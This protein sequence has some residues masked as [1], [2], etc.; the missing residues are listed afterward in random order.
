LNA[1]KISI[2]I[3]VYNEI[4][5]LEK[6]LDKVENT[7]FCSL[8]KEIILV[9][10]KSSDGTGD[11]LRDL[12][13]KYAETEEN[14]PALQHKVYFHSENMGKGGAI[15]TALGYA[16]GDI[17][18]I[19]DADLE[20]DPEDYN[21]LIPF[22]LEDKADVVYGSRL[23]GEKTSETFRLSHYVGNKVLTLITNILYN[24]SLTDME[25]CYK[26]FKA[27]IIKSISI[28]SNRFDFEPE[29]TA[30]ILK[31]KCRIQEVPI[32]YYGRAHNEGKKITWKDGFGAIR[33]LILFRFFD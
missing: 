5:T 14:F 30:K 16:T 29:I 33:A 19:Q 22:I 21:R 23:S 15:R 2:I 25:T 4:N 20:Y 32:S 27:D 8:E 24:T 3:P 18:V 13:K 11:L 10:D 17:I 28:K 1:K 9:D 31:K 6:I 7:N 12:E 26:A